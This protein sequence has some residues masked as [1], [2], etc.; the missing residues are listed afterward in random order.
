MATDPLDSDARTVWQSQRTDPAPVDIADIRGRSLK[1]RRQ[2]WRR[3]LGEYAAS[4]LVVAVF[5]LFSWTA[6]GFWTRTGALLV[7]GGTLY[8]CYELHKRGSIRT[9]SPGASSVVFHRAELERQRDALQSVWRWYLAPFVPGLTVHAVGQ[10]ID[11][12]PISWVTAAAH[13]RFPG[14]RVRGHPQA[15]PVGR[16]RAAAR[17]RRLDRVGAGRLNTTASIQNRPPLQRVE[18]SWRPCRRTPLPGDDD[19]AG[20]GPRGEIVL[21]S[22]HPCWESG[23]E[24]RRLPRQ[25]RLGGN[26]WPQPGRGRVR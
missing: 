24:R 7:I 15:E 2:I 26:R 12:P 18:Y 4:A 1:F 16:A 23:T 22:S 13:A 8:M 19:G 20:A 6:D 25:V 17:D 3:N 11:N 9:A 5:G 10:E 14:R 21:A